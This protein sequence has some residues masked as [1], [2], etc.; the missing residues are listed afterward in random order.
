MRRCTKCGVHAP[1]K[2]QGNVAETNRWMA[3]HAKKHRIN[4]SKRKHWG[5]LFSER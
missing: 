3:K 1:V 4:L 5:G 2:L